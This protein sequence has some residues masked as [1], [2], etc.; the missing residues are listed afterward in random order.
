MDGG[1]WW[2]TVPQGREESDTTERLHFTSLISLRAH[3]R[4]CG[5]ARSLQLCPTLHDPMEYSLP[6]SSV[7]EILQARV[8]CQALLQGIFLTQRLNPNLFYLLQWQASSLPLSHQ[9]SPSLCKNM[10]VDWGSQAHLSHLQIP[11]TQSI[12]LL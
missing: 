11:E 12:L 9:G 5:C 6:G 8:G 3:A 1:A 7:P 2:A 4:V 10:H